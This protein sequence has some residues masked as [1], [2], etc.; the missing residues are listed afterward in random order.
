[1][2]VVINEAQIKRNRQFS[3]ILVI[4]S[5]AGMVIGFFYNFSADPSQSSQITC[6][7]MPLLLLMTLT[8]VRMSN[9]WIREPR[10]ENV[11]SDGLKGFGQKYTVFHY[12]LPAPHVLIA[13]EGVFTI[14]TVWQDRPYR[15]EGKK[16]HGE[17]GLMKKIGGYMRQDLIGN[18]FQDALIEAQQVQ[19]MV[20]KIAPDAGV[21]VQPLIVFIHPAA[22]FEAEDP[23][24]PV[25]YADNKK[26][27]SLRNYLRDQKDAG[28]ATLTDEALDQIDEM[29]KLVTR[30]EIAAMLGETLTDD[31]ETEDFIADELDDEPSAEPIEEGEVGTVFVAQA[32]QLFYIGVAEDL[33]GDELEALQEETD[34]EVELI[35]S[36][37]TPNPAKVVNDLQRKFARK[38][39]KDNWYGLSQKDISHLRSR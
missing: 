24:F 3:H 20:D 13:P 11:L 5:L 14:R 39:Q 30:A 6:F 18:P 23:L 25:L 35:H 2:R 9:N 4:V 27:L 31:E 19:K 34:K 7:V 10:P 36:F 15:V 28:R 16:W 29:Y 1:M 33:I 12:L 21:E 37:E 17:E 32:G 26:K 38:K 22:S 8:S